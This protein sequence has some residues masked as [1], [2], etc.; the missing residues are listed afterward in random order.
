MSDIRF[1]MIGQG[2]GRNRCRTL[3][4]TE[5]AKLIAT[6]DLLKQ[7]REEAEEE[8]GVPSYEDYRQL[9]DRDDIDV[10]GIFTP[11][12]MRREIALDA[13]DAGKHVLCTKP[14]EVNIERCD[15]M[16]KAAEEKG[17]R[18]V[19]DF[20]F[21]YTN[22]MLALKKAVDDGFFGDLL[23]GKAELKWFRNQEYYDWNNG[24]RGTW[25]WDGGG[26]LANQT[27]H[28][29]DEL[30]WLMGPVDS[31]FA[32]VGV[33]KWD[34][35]AEDQGVAVVRFKNGGLGTICGATT[36]VPYVEMDRVEL[37][38][39]KGNAITMSTSGSY[40]AGATGAAQ[41]VEQWHV[42]G[43]DGKAELMEPWKMPEGPKNVFEDIVSMLTKGTEP[44]VDGVEARKS[45]E[46]LNAIY[47]SSQTGKEVKFP[48]EKA[49]VPKDGY[50][51]WTPGR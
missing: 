16:I 40:E 46:I 4:N 14:M 35:E 20:I 31:V 25:R 2:V 49:F 7:R 6:C 17:K 44:L 18:L 15:D 43:K 36:S 13:F 3:M 47:E 48:V 27:V 23:L 12:G 45:I 9:L 39:T 51:D 24:W 26:S 30:Q 22:N 32:Y 8:F 29:I 50:R 42:M 19:V 41:H 10:I 34:I 1:G 37:L 33:H 11:A 5:G 28:Y 38:G 21:R